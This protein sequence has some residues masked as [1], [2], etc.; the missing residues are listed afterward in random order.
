MKP[1]VGQAQGAKTRIRTGER[2]RSRYRIITL[3]RFPT[4]FPVRLE[5][6]QRGAQAV[7]ARTTAARRHQR[8]L[9]ISFDKR[10]ALPVLL[11]QRCSQYDREVGEPAVARSQRGTI[12]HPW[13]E[14][15]MPILAMSYELYCEPGREY[16]DLFKAIGNFPDRF[17][18]LESM[19]II[20]TPKSPREVFKILEPHL[21]NKDKVL[22][23]P[24]DLDAGC[25]SPPLPQEVLNWCSGK[26]S[27]NWAWQS[28]I[29]SPTNQSTNWQGKSKM[30]PPRSGMAD[31]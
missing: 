19:W 27:I 3:Y 26:Q 14:K 4:P 5:Y 8:L 20:A 31:Q 24:L 30:T 25:Y 1:P 9:G 12:R 28:K 17:H 13:V 10:A 29:S 2:V 16:E 7:H 6:G 22:I 21:H 15:P 11:Q 23:T 18:A